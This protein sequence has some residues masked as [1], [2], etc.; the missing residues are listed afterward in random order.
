MKDYKAMFYEVK[1]TMDKEVV[2]YASSSTTHRCI[3]IMGQVSKALENLEKEY[4]KKGE[5]E[6]AW[7]NTVDLFR[8]L[9]KDTKNIMSQTDKYYFNPFLRKVFKKRAE[10][11]DTFSTIE[12]MLFVSIEPILDKHTGNDRFSN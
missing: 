12:T 9:K 4:G 7:N 2:A 11:Y 5:W 1:T 8:S 10:T 3:C 6:T